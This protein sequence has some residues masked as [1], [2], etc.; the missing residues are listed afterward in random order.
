LYG[1]YEGIVAYGGVAHTVW[2]DDRPDNPLVGGIFREAMYTA[3]I[4]YGL[5]G[6]VDESAFPPVSADDLVSVLRSHKR[7]FWADGWWIDR[8][9]G[10]SDG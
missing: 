7:G 5:R 10:L 8:A 2:S 3:N 1:D 6:G 4:E 9:D